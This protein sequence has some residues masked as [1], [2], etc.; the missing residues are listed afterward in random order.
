MDNPPW[1]EDLSAE[2]HR[3]GRWSRGIW[4]VG[5]ACAAL[6]VVLVLREAPTGMVV[7]GVTADGM[8]LSVGV[9]GECDGRVVVLEE[10]QDDVV[11]AAFERRDLLP[12]F[13]GSECDPPI[14]EVSL[15]DPL[16][17]RK[18]YDARNGELVTVYRTEPGA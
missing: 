18:V 11:L 17:D 7:E 15:Q 3:A 16:G 13:G 14:F 10:T 12:N 8:T 2:A 9:G 1:S 4:A 6:V 5:L